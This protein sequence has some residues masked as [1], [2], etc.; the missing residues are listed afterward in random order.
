MISRFSLSK[1]IK[2]EEGCSKSQPDSLTVVD[3][4]GQLTKLQSSLDAEQQ[5]KEAYQKQVLWL[6]KQLQITKDKLKSKC[7]QSRRSV[8]LGM[9]STIK[10]IDD[11][12][13]ASEA[14]RTFSVQQAC[15]TPIHI[16][17]SLSNNA[18]SWSY[19]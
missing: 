11:Y 16:T 14:I 1:S 19:D 18:I 12:C 15:S 2:Q 8:S 6:R 10:Y 3:L 9:L 13:N 17:E 4:K 7:S 5:E